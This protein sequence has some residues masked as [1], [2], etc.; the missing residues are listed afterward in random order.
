LA[1]SNLNDFASALVDDEDG[2]RLTAQERARIKAEAEASVGQK[3]GRAARKVRDA[4]E[5][6]WE[7]AFEAAQARRAA[8]GADADEVA[9]WYKTLELEEGADLDAVRKSYRKLMRQYHPDRYANDPE[10]Y[11]AANKVATKVTAAYNG[12]RRLLELQ[13]G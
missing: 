4:A 5:D 10:K 6:A 3:A 11:E 1:R 12:L 7:Q 9:R 2:T 13:D 8:G